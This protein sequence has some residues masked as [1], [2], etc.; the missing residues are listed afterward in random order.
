MLL[1]TKMKEY[2]NEVV[3]GE[4]EEIEKALINQAIR[5]C[6]ETNALEGAKVVIKG[7]CNIQHKEYAYTE[8]TIRLVD[9]VA[10]LMY[11]EPCSTVPV[12]KRKKEAVL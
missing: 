5:K 3:F 11:G 9:K 6:I 2:A 7:C 12:F 10:N 4:E 8:L 1:A